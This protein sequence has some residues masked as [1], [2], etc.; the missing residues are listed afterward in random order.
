MA[1]AAGFWD[2]VSVQMSIDSVSIFLGPG[3]EQAG[4]GGPEP[5]DQL[6][7]EYPAGS[8][9]TRTSANHFQVIEVAAVAL[10]G[11]CTNPRLQLNI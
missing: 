9:E 4:F 8:K 7:N 6:G 10:A 5:E 1:A 3:P 11:G 2:C